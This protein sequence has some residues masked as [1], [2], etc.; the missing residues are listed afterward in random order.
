MGIESG[1]G[2]F[3]A[4]FW[5]DVSPWSY[6]GNVVVPPHEWTHVAASFDGSE[7]HFVSSIEVETRALSGSLVN[8]MQVSATPD[9]RIGSRTNT[10]AG[11]A[12]N[13]GNIGHNSEFIGDIDEVMPSNMLSHAFTML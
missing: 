5:T 8:G 11:S 2:H 6:F 10:Y 13:E 3:Q 1:T 9:L 4:A 12:A 7:H